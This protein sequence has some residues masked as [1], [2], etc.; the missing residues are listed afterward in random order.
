MLQCVV[1]RSTA[2]HASPVCQVYPAMHVLL[3]Q[4]TNLLSTQQ[5]GFKS[6]LINENR[7]E[8]LP[9]HVSHILHASPIPAS[10]PH[11]GQKHKQAIGPSFYC[12]VQSGK[13]TF[14]EHPDGSEHVQKPTVA[15]RQLT[16]RAASLEECSKGCNPWLY[17]LWAFLKLWMCRR[18]GTV[19]LPLAILKK[20]HC[21]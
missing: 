13:P 12:V 11:G 16:V 14:S 21:V 7:S 15:C 3:G 4:C 2:C 1:G 20:Y 5:Q 8:V 6:V 10:Q 17:K 19:D 9:I 18:Y